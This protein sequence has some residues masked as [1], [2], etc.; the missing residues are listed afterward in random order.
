MRAL[1][2]LVLISLVF[3]ALGQESVPG[4]VQGG[5]VVPE[6]GLLT[7]AKEQCKG[8]NAVWCVVAGLSAV[9]LV[10]NLTTSQSARKTNNQLK[11][12]SDWG[13]NGYDPSTDP[14]YQQL[15]LE[16]QKALATLKELEKKGY[17]FNP[18]TG[19]M[20][21]PKGEATAA[22]LASGKALADAGLIDH[23]QAGEYDKAMSEQ[24]KNKIKVVSMSPGGG[25]GG[26]KRRPASASA[27]DDY[28]Y[29]SGI[30]PS[31]IRAAKTSGLSKNFGNDPVG[32][33]TDNLF[34]MVH[35]KYQDLN[36]KDT[37]I[38]EGSSR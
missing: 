21:T 2:V 9:Q 6:S 4:A 31:Q 26:A 19:G 22:Q 7:K 33:A 20:T 10:Q 11:A 30:D 36:E 8:F 32:V 34:D 14:V 17:K 16:K 29:R 12:D 38:K 35:R 13:P 5:Q 27:S 23:S 18:K 28:A 24:Q 37:F 3:P 15:E 1:V 25:G